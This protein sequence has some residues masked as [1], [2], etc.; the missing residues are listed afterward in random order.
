MLQSR[1]GGSDSCNYTFLHRQLFSVVSVEGQSRSEA[2]LIKVQV[3]S[4]WSLNCF[5]K[6]AGAELRITR[7]CQPGGLYFWGL[8]AALKH[9]VTVSK[10]EQR[11]AISGAHSASVFSV[12]VCYSVSSPSPVWSL[13][14]PALLLIRSSV[15]THTE[16][17]KGLNHIQRPSLCWLLVAMAT[18]W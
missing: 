1:S 12:C 6:Y 8:K 9:R 2:S 14:T 10:T 17:H 4:V 3:R 16:K 5:L 15:E 11:R 18:P 13:R 7:W